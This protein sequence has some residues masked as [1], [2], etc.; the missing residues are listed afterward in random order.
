MSQMLYCLWM[1]FRRHWHW[2]AKQSMSF[3]PTNVADITFLCFC[4]CSRACQIL[5]VLFLTPG[6][7]SSIVLACAETKW[8]QREST[9]PVRL[10]GGLKPRRRHAQS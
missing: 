2:S 10:G 3:L 9:G 5:L 4:G 8:F 7:A 6:R 1:R